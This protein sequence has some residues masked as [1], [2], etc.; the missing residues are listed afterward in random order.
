MNVHTYQ[1]AVKFLLLNNDFSKSEIQYIFEDDTNQEI[2][3]Q[4]YNDGTYPIKAISKLILFK[5]E[6]IESSWDERIF[7]QI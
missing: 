1:S 6:W 4:C 3:T 2:L 5:E 7:T